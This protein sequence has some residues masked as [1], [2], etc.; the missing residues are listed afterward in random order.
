MRYRD[1]KYLDFL[2]VLSHSLRKQPVSVDAD[3][4]AMQFTPT[5]DFRL[6]PELDTSHRPATDQPAATFSC[7]DYFE[8]PAR[9]PLNKAG[10]LFKVLPR[11]FGVELEMAQTNLAKVSRVL[12][13]ALPGRAREHTDVYDTFARCWQVKMDEPNV[14][15]ATPIL[16][17]SDDLA[18]LKR[19][20]A[21]LA[22]SGATCDRGTGVHVH[23]DAAEIEAQ[24]L[25]YLLALVAR[26]EPYIFAALRVERTRQESYCRPLAWPRVVR[27]VR[28]QPKTIDH[29]AAVFRSNPTVA[30]FVGLNLEQVFCPNG[31]NTIEFRYFNGCLDPH[32]IGCYVG[33]AVAAMQHTATTSSHC[34]KAG[35]ASLPRLLRTLGLD[36]EDDVSQLLCQQLKQELEQHMRQMPRLIKH[37]RAEHYTGDASLLLA[38]G[39]PAIDLELALGEGPDAASLL[40]CATCLLRLLSLEDAALGFAQLQKLPAKDRVETAQLATQL[41]DHRRFGQ[42]AAK[43]LQQLCRLPPTQR[44]AWVVT[45]KR[46]PVALLVRF[47]PETIPN[48]VAVFS[49][50][51]FEYTG[52]PSAV[53]LASKIL[54]LISQAP[55]VV[56]ARLQAMAKTPWLRLDDAALRGRLIFSL[57]DL[58]PKNIALLDALTEPILPHVTYPDTYA[59]L[60]EA[61]CD[62][63]STKWSAY[64]RCVSAV[65]SG[66]LGLETLSALRDGT[67]VFNDIFQPGAFQNE[68]RRGVS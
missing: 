64:A 16:Q 7:A 19:V 45:A 28:A 58:A 13:D 52:F 56:D 62:A 21:A 57:L 50:L 44:A 4:R 33:Y 24:A 10:S 67:C 29:L 60:I 68:R 53:A 49:R 42:D 66:P 31:Y 46:A 41:L 38:M 8:P 17:T 18:M 23:V 12:Q 9:R 61:F 59:D 51:G 26:H 63:A 36:P 3:A 43:V 47:A 2:L 22:L 14:E 35:G 15:V 6:C 20:V 48:L 32:A 27:A 30:R 55:G 34:T 40:T 5:I 39:V 1:K 25:T 37:V 11:R 54:S 65:L